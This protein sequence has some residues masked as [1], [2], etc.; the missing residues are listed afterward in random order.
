MT[1]KLKIIVIGAGISGLAAAQ[2]LVAHGYDVVVLEARNCIGGRIRTDYSLGFP[3]N[4]GA[5]WLHGLESNPVAQLAQQANVAFKPS[6]FA[7]TLF[8]D[9]QQKVIPSV[10]VN[11]FYKQQEDFLAEVSKKS[12]STASSFSLAAVMNFLKP[13]N[14]TADNEE[15]WQW[16]LTCLELYTGA[17]LTRLSARYWD[18]EEIFPG[19]NHFVTGSYQ[20]IINTLAHNV[21]IKFNTRVNKINYQNKLIR[22]QTNRGELLADLMICTLPLG[23][24]QKGIVQFEPEFHETTFMHLEMGVLNRIA[25]YF[26]SI[27]WPIEYNNIYISPLQYPFI[28]FFINLQNYLQQP[29]LMGM[30][31]GDN[32]QQIELFSDADVIALAM[33]DLRRAFGNA[34]PQPTKHLITRWGQDPFTYGSYSYVPYCSWGDEYDHM[35]IRIEDR[36]FFAGEATNRQYPGTTHGAYLSG[37]READRIIKLSKK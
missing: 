15:L 30:T 29:V 25:L 17:D 16:H 7:D 34:I 12:Y 26:P 37:I 21:N 27:F 13:K 23:V 8:F 32:A 31:G 18:E 6:G 3:L 5:G 11:D 10:Q 33:E 14:M 36:I 4:T 35:A 24:L 28:A 9:Q 20:S 22:V 2:K 1:K 19:G